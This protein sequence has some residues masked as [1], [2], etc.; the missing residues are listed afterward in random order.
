METTEKPVVSG[1]RVYAAI[2]NV[3][4]DLSK[5]GITKDRKNQQQG[6]QFRGIDDMYNAISHLLA[7]HGLAILPRV[8]T[9]KQVERSTKN[10]GSLFWTFVEVEFDFVSVV[11]G[12]KHTAKTF[13]EAMDTADKSTNKAMSAAYKYVVMQT[14]C[15]PTEG[16][17]D[18]DAT[19]HEVAPKP[20]GQSP[21]PASKAAAK[22]A[23]KAPVASMTSE[24]RERLIELSSQMSRPVFADF[25]KQVTGR[26]PDKNMTE[27]EAAKL[28]KALDDELRGAA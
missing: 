4:A 18:A 28:I 20:P 10:G 22:P 3:A 2:A 17:N 8:L 16:D 6:Y 1:P 12:S 5:D 7:R 9:R 21:K 14:F 23:A 13:G 11:D 25:C 15:I 26:P 19:T 24:Q 27:V